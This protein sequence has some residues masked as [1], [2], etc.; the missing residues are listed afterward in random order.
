MNAGRTIPEFSPARE[1]NFLESVFLYLVKYGEDPTSGLNYGGECSEKTGG[2]KNLKTT[3]DGIEIETPIP[4]GDSPLIF[5]HPFPC[6]STDHVD[7]IRKCWSSTSSS[8]NLSSDFGEHT[9]IEKRLSQN[10]TLTI[11]PPFQSNPTK[12]HS[13]SCSP[14][15]KSLPV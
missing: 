4:H 10:R 1:R 15:Q 5:P 2:S 9:Q 7:P 14:P 11:Y 8:S 3:P 13:L 6:P 12:L